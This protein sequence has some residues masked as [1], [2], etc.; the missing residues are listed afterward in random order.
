MESI[1]PSHCKSQG[2]EGL[3][4]TW[5]E[6]FKQSVPTTESQIAIKSES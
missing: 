3:V 6:T 2:K 5:M 1:F 4:G